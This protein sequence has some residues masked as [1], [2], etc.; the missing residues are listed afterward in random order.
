MQHSGAVGGGHAMTE[1]AQIGLIGL[2]TMGANLALNMAENGHAIA[3]FNRTASRTRDFVAGAG[4][5]SKK[6]IPTDSLEGFVAALGKPRRIVLMVPAGRPVDDQIAALRPLLEAGDIIVD[7]GN[8]DWQD[9]GRRERDLGDIHFLGLGVSGGADGARHGPSM[10]AGGTAE[11]Y[12]AMEEVLTDIA[13]MH[14]D[15]PCVAHL[16]PEGAGHYVKMVHNGIEYADMQMIAEIYGLLRFGTGRS[17]TDIGV[18]FGE[19][20]GG[21]LKSYLVEITG[22][23]LQYDDP[24]TGHPVVD[25]IK[26][27]A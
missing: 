18:L 2:G 16:G 8:S 25:V 19:W 9:T 6:L 5:L 14:G 4:E 27:S 24:K 20:N 21:A 12:G 3:V 15:S 22:K 13:A 23:A 1:T 17:P 10:M 11:A 7:A 26:D